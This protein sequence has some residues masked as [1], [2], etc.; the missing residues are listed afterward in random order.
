MIGSFRIVSAEASRF[1]IVFQTGKKDFYD[2]KRNVEFPGFSFLSFILSM[3]RGTYQEGPEGTLNVKGEELIV[4]V[5]RS[6]VF[7]KI[8]SREG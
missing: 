7:R 8:Y 2:V 4:G 6:P 3:R 1:V 5:S